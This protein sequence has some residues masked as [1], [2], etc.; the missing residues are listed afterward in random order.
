MAHWQKDAGI[1]NYGSKVRTR[2]DLLSQ[3]RS[4]NTSRVRV[5]VYAYNGGISRTYNVGS[6][7]DW[8]ISGNASASGSKTFDIPAKSWHTFVDR[9]FTVTHK[10]DGTMPLS[11]TGAIT[12]TGTS[13]L[14]S[15]G[16]A[17][18][19]A[20]LPKL[21]LA[22]TAPSWGSTGYLSESRVRASWTNK[23]TARGP[24]SSLEVQRHDGKAWRAL[25]TLGASATS[26]SDASIPGNTEVRYR[27]RAK[28]PGGT[29]GWVQGGTLG[30][31]PAA[32][33]G[34]KAVKSGQ[35]IVVSWTDNAAPTGRGRTF[36]IDDAP[37]GGSWTRVGEVS[38]ATSWTHTDADPAKTHRYRVWTRITSQI[39]LTS[40]A[41]GASSTVQ[42]QAPPNRPGR[43]E[44]SDSSTQ[45]VGDELRFEWHHNPVDTTPQTAAEFAYRIDGGDW[46]TSEVGSDEHIALTPDAGDRTRARLEWRVRTKGDHP[47]WS[48]WSTTNG[49]Q[50]STVPSVVIQEPVDGGTLDVSRM[51]VSWGYE[52]NGDESQLD[53]SQWRATLEREDSDGTTAWVEEQSESGTDSSV[54]FGARLDNDTTYTV[55]VEVEN[56]DGL[57]SEADT[58]TVLTDFPTPVLV[59]V[60]P[61]WDRG[62]G[63]VALSFGE[64]ESPAT[65]AWEGEPYASRSTREIH[66]ETVTNEVRNPFG[67][68]AET[69]EGWRTTTGDI[70]TIESEEGRAAA[71]LVESGDNESLYLD[72]QEH[73]SPPVGTVV[74]FS[75]DVMVTVPVERMRARIATYA[76]AEVEH[77]GDGGYVAQSPEDGWVRYEDEVTITAMPDDGY[78][79]TLVWPASGQFEEGEGFYVRDA[80]LTFDADPE[81]EFFDGSFES[82]TDAEAI[83]VERRDEGGDWLLI[84]SGIDSGDTIIDRTPRIGDVEYRA[85]SRTTLPTERTG[86]TAVAEWVH[87]QD[88]FYVNGGNGMARV[89]RGRGSEA[90]DTYGIE[91]TSHQFA[92]RSRPTPFFGGATEREVTASGRILHVPDLHEVSTRE[93]WVDLLHQFAVVCFRDCRGR[94]VFGLLEVSFDTQRHVETVSVKVTETEW[95]EG[96]QRVSD[97]DLEEQL[98]G[99]DEA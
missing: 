71:F 92:G 48:P 41:S 18:V 24:Y 63:A 6:G 86:E 38:S 33:S 80:L 83:D 97:L 52:P 37:D 69:T 22:P 1:G 5:R 74:R 30:T 59:D 90:A 64:A 76:G 13:A 23:A 78:L 46:H 68:E 95:E 10:A 19:T 62:E 58:A 25:I 66:G 4:A 82:R 94:K 57:W 84:A 47:D 36:Y 8:R 11:I 89:C 60:F 39:E 55:T 65:Y 93:D 32:A 17:K 34:V 98:G 45:I 54:T 7:A 44:P 16:T 21:I 12:N 31:T 14:G 75:I 67:P 40:K 50:L 42:L 2:V 96:V 73:P 91:Q 43:D 28:G 9:E 99:G 81:T 77:A 88:P 35:S 26:V 3:N 49:P 87:D 51:A 70:L 85:V 53:Q 15:G 29:S 72:P 27:V 20:T 61:E 56:G 79:R